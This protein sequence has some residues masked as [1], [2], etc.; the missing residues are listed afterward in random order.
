MLQPECSELKDSTVV[1][2]MAPDLYQSLPPLG[3]VLSLM[4]TRVVVLSPEAAREVR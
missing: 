4:D 2:R 3:G 1:R